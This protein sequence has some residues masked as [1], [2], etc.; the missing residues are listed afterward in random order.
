MR[1]YV[2]LPDLSK[3]SKLSKLTRSLVGALLECRYLK[4]I[5]SVRL[6]VEALGFKGSFLAFALF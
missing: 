2:P 1:R 5:K 6:N 4:L 3:C